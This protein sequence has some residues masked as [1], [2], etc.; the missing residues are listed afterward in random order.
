M[1]AGPSRGATRGARGRNSPKSPNNVISTFFRS[2]FASERPQVRTEGRQ[3]CFLPRAPS[4]LVTPLERSRLN[5]RKVA[6]NLELLIFINKIGSNFQK[7]IILKRLFT[8]KGLP[9]NRI[10][11]AKNSKAFFSRFRSKNDPRPTSRNEC[12]GQHGN[13]ET[14]FPKP[15]GHCMFN[16]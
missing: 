5:P 4:N 7:K 11:F 10:H 3:T 6:T 16:C 14:I 1:T 15:H 8:T 12:G 2:T 9:L 13:F